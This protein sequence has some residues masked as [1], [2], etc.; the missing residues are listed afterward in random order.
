MYRTNATHLGAGLMLAA[1]LLLV[2]AA[3]PVA[4]APKEYLYVQARF[5]GN[6]VVVSIPDHEVVGDIPA[7]VV[8]QFPDSIAASPDGRVIYVNRMYGPDAPDVL[9]ISTSTEEVLWRLPVGAT[10]HHII[11][12]RDGKYLFVP[13]F[14]WKTL[15]VIDLERREIVA[16]PA[17]GYGGHS[18]ELSPDGERV[19]VGGITSGTISVVDARSHETLRR[20]FLGEGVRPFQISPDEKEIYVQMSHL[21]GFLVLDAETGRVKQEVRLP[22]LKPEN[23]AKK[24]KEWPYTVNHGMRLTEDGKRLFV[25]ASLSDYVGVYSLPEFELIAMMPTGAEPGYLELSTDESYLYSS[26]RADNTIS[27]FS[28][29]SLEEIRR[30]ENVGDFPQRMKAVM[31][32]ERNVRR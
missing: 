11:T 17:I 1:V 10:P 22:P 3:A 4:A 7:S 19:Y 31:V 18:I 27:V 6:I 21:H 23:A 13:A 8:G 5:S 28:V 30:I 20:F 24:S 14:G 15:E 12:S 32:P 29:D 9:A 26:N 16:R 25:A 2:Q